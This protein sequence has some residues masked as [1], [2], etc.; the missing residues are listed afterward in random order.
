MFNSLQCKDI[1]S[2]IVTFFQLCSLP[3]SDCYLKCSVIYS[4]LSVFENSQF[5]MVRSISSSIILPQLLTVC[6]GAKK[7]SMVGP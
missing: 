3:V 5:F 7:T 2:I 6:L 4:K 1:V